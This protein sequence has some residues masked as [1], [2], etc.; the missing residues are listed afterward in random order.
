LI[1]EAGWFPDDIE[2]TYERSFK[3]FAELVNDGII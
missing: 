1:A 2:K 3:K